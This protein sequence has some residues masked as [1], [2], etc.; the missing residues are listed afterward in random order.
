MGKNYR[1]RLTL[2]PDEVSAVSR[3]NMAVQPIKD[4]FGR[5]ILLFLATLGEL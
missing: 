2:E 5:N 1:D 4:V 3:F